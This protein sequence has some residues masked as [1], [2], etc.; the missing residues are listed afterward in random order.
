MIAGKSTF[1]RRDKGYFVRS[2]EDMQL[3]CGRQDV[4]T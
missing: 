2:M 4:H 3:V 1:P